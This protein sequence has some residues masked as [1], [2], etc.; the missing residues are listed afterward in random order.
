MEGRT[1]GTGLENP[2]SYNTNYANESILLD[3]C[4]KSISKR[5]RKEN[6]YS[7]EFPIDKV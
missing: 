6:F 5:K 4:I 1:K 7:Y 3:I 2:H